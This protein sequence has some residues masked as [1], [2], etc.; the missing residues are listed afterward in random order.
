MLGL[1]IF[2][3]AIIRMKIFLIILLLSVSVG[4]EAQQVTIQ[5]DISTGCNPLLVSFSIQPESARDSITAYE[6][7]FGNW[8]SLRTEMFPVVEFPMGSFDVSCTIS[9]I[10]SSYSITQMDS[11]NEMTIDVMNCD[12]NLSIPNVFS[13]NDDNINDFFKIDTDGISEYTFSVYTRSGTLVY[14]SRSPTI[15]WDGRSL[16]GQKMKN[17]IYFYIISRPDDVPLN[18]VKGIV[19]L[20]E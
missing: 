13:P 10:D 11:V 4:M 14:K 8:T 15:I 5:A 12:D 19:Y 16:S 20:F 3:D 1:N 18:E 6:W 2:T 9:T 7:N 17:G